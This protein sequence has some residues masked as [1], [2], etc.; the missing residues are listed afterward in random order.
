MKALLAAGALALTACV[1]DLTRVLIAGLGLVLAA[2]VALIAR[3]VR[4]MAVAR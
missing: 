4:R 1:P 3:S 2:E